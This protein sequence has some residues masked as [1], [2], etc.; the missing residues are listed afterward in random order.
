MRKKV[1]QLNIEVVEADNVQEE[2]DNV[3]L[4]PGRIKAY[5]YRAWDKF[6]VVMI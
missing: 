6:D 1:K 5:D 4:K 2:E 3:E